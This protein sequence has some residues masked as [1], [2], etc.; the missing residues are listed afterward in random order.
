M[1]LS[2]S[3]NE[4]QDISALFFPGVVEGRY[5]GCFKMDFEAEEKNCFDSD[6]CIRLLPEIYAV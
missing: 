6:S 2:F 3:R 4:L 5:I 1:L